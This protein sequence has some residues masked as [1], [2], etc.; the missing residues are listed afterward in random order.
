[1]LFANNPPSVVHFW[2]TWIQCQSSF[3]IFPL[4]Y[5]IFQN[6]CL[7]SLQWVA[8]KRAHVSGRV[9]SYLPDPD[10]H[11]PIFIDWGLGQF[12]ICLRDSNSDNDGKVQRDNTPSTLV[13]RRARRCDTTAACGDY[14]VGTVKNRRTAHT[15]CS[16]CGY[17]SDGGGEDDDAGSDGDAR[18]TA[19]V[20]MSEEAAAVRL[21][22]YGSVRDTFTCPTIAGSGEVRNHVFVSITQHHTQFY[23][24]PCTAPPQHRILSRESKNIFLFSILLRRRTTI[25]EGRAYLR[26]TT[27]PGCCF[28]GWV[29]Q[30]STLFRTESGPGLTA[31]G[32]LQTS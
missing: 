16:W 14:W 18:W 24:A 6:I 31:Q 30:R 29:E 25:F 3:V 27:V 17:D 21:R 23:T 26:P 28:V 8:S 1:M 19:W 15:L 22:N 10:S 13:P 20:L 9:I 7:K 12:S 11:L 5:D 2:S 4:I 32:V